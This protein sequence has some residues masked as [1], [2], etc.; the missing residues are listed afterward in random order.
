MV[1]LL[2]GGHCKRR[3]LCQDFGL[4][5][6]DNGL[7][8]DLRAEDVILAEIRLLQINRLFTAFLEDKVGGGG[9]VHLLHLVHN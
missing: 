9:R 8:D 6:L 4:R 3:F 1:P 7:T 5:H 2:V